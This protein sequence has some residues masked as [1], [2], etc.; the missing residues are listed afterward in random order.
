MANRFKTIDVFV[1][2]KI[3]MPAQIV[4]V[5]K[6]DQVHTVDLTDI[7]VNPGGGL[8][9]ADF[10]LP[11]VDKNAGWQLKSDKYEE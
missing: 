11:D 1:D 4:T 8:K 10:V 5:G 7:Q 3:S 9:D 2:R 6:D